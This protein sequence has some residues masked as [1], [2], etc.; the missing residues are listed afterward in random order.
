MRTQLQ[1]FKYLRQLMITS[2]TQMLLYVERLQ[3]VTFIKQDVRMLIHQDNWRSL[4][5]E[6]SLAHKTSL[7]DGQKPSV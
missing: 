5:R 1:S 2:Q 3:D 6:K 7:S 4:Q